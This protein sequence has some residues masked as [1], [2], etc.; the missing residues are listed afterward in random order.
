MGLSPFAR[1]SKSVGHHIWKATVAQPTA[2]HLA[3]FMKLQS[4]VDMTAKITAAV[5]AAILLTSAGA[6]SAQTSRHVTRTN[7]PQVRT[8]AAWQSSDPY[9]NKDYWDRVAPAGKIQLHDPFVGTY[10]E[11]VVP[12]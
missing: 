10:F 11:G 9:Y 3:F 8:S 4:E 5:L 12:Y 6:A 7:T 2:A 1:W